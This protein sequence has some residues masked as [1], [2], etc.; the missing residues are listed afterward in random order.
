MICLKDENIQFISNVGEGGDI[1][2][3]GQEGVE[4]L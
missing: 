1:G 2:D 4:R 3:G